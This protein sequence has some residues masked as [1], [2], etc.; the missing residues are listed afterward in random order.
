M[1]KESL[2]TEATNIN[3]FAERF[4]SSVPKSNSKIILAETDPF[5]NPFDAFTATI[6]SLPPASIHP[7]GSHSITGF[8][9]H[10]KK[11]RYFYEPLRVLHSSQLRGNTIHVPASNIGDQI[12][13]V[14][15]FNL[16][17]N[18]PL[19]QIVDRIPV[20]LIVLN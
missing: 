14:I 13:L 20:Q 7:S 2:H 17:R 11:G 8:L 9:V 4:S 15:E 6:A 3:T 16:N 1:I 10:K 18:S 19:A 12:L 5:E